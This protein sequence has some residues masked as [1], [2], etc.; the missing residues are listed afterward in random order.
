MQ[1]FILSQETKKQAAV[2][3]SNNTEKWKKWLQALKVRRLFVVCTYA[4]AIY[5]IYIHHS[6]ED[7]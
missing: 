1:Q 7:P 2:P 3:S 4:I 6:Y 5:V